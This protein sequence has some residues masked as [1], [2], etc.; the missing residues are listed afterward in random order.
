CAT[1]PEGSGLS[2][3]RAEDLG[4]EGGGRLDERAGD[5]DLAE[6]DLEAAA[7]PGAHRLERDERLVDLA[8]VHVGRRLDD[9][10]AA[11]GDL[12]AV[13][14]VRRVDDPALLAEVHEAHELAD[15]DVAELADALGPLGL[16]GR[17][18]GV[19]HGPGAAH[20]LAPGRL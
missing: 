20:A 7:L 5:L 13:L 19:G 3:G 18:E 1:P 6:D 4:E 2:A 15:Q 17:R 8:V 11:E 14:L 16:L 9:L 12:A 10:A